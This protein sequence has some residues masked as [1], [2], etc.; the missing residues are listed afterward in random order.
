MPLVSATEVLKP[1]RAHRYAVGAF[2]CI[3]LEY[4]RAVVD[5]AERLRSPVMVA[6]TT[7]ALSYAG[8][9]A[10]P[11]AVR[12]V[13]EAAHVPVVLHLDHGQNLEDIRRA[14]EAGF[15]SV[16]IDASHLPLEENIA[17]TRQ[18][19]QM[20]H[21]AGVSLEGELGQ[22]GGKEEEIVSAG[23]MTDPETVPYFVEA[24]G[25]DV[26][27]AS[28]GSVH[29]KATR[30]A[31][32]D[33]PRLEKIAAATPLPLVLHGGSGVPTEML[34]AATARGVAKVNVGTELQRTFARVLRETLKAQPEEWDMRK[35]LKP[36]I[37][38][39]AAV[40]EERLGVLG[41]VGRA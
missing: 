5:T 29:Q 41:S 38:A 28:F 15:S 11:A 1:A 39:I 2:N 12:A 9:E 23:L 21:A 25:I 10:L 13:A 3:N 7:G 33:L 22:I 35:L 30:D 37:N 20:A 6:V 19:A 8:W 36:S 16:M 26:L 17:L 24:T 40:V 34:Q 14:L 4:V 27:A 32:L 31:Q 18:A